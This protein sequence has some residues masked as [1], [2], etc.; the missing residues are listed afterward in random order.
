[1]KFGLSLLEYNILNDLIVTPLRGKGFELWIFGSRA[2]GDHQK[3]S[4]IDIL[5]KAPTDKE[6]SAI[7]SK[8]KEDIE[9]RLFPYKVDF[10]L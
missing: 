6:W 5:V 8:I 3:F 10:V 9:E 1:M 2:R 4:D 7:L